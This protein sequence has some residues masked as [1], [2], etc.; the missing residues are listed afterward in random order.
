M[1]EFIE[2][3]KLPAYVLCLS[4]WDLHTFALV[5][6]VVPLEGLLLKEYQA[7]ERD[8]PIFV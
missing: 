5:S 4:R 2:Q 1:A 6:G 3:V 7:G 8:H